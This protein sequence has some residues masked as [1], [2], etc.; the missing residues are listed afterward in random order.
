MTKLAVCGLGLLG[1]P[2]AARLVEAGHDVTV[3]NR[4][5]EKADPLVELG[6]RRAETPEEAAAGA[7]VVVT[8]LS[9]PEVLDR[10]VLG[11]QGLAAGMGRGSTLVEMS[12]IG[13][14]A[15]QALAPRLPEGVELVDAPVLGSVPQATEG[16]LKVFVGGSAE[17]FERLRPLLEVLGTPRHIGPL[18]SGAAMKLTVNSTLG[19]LMAALGEALA[20]ADAFGLD[21]GAV[22]DVLADSALGVT[23]KGKRGRIESGVFEPN[24]RLDMAHKDSVLITEAAARRGVDLPVARAVRDVLAAAERQ[25]YGDQDYSAVIAHIRG[26]GTTR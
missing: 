7:E 20:L 25:G 1:R 11:P 26:A 14:D 12:T 10:V 16:T 18:G 21:Q 15:V 23:T 4:T 17:Q 22:M 8:V 9:T 13:P 24:F 6:A 19:P 2:I 5:P 3:W